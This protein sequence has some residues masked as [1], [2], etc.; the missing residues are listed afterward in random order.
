V[1]AQPAPSYDAQ[2]DLLTSLTQWVEQGTAPSSVIATK[3]KNDT[4]QLGVAMR[5]P[6]CSYPQIP[7]YKGGDPSAA[8][9]FK[10]VADERGDIN[11]KPAPQY[12]PQPP[13]IRIKSS[14]VRR[15]ILSPGRFVAA[16][17]VACL[18]G[19]PGD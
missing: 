13:H 18:P 15:Q 9:S 3:Y 2:Y 17:E 19:L 7:V 11:P 1:I 8:A 5:R 6:I 4:P 14:G 16:A 10:C 12:A